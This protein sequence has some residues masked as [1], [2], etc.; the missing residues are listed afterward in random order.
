MEV[1]YM[2]LPLSLAFVA[3]IGGILWWAVFSGQYDDPDHAAH[4]ILRDND[5]PVPQQSQ[6]ISS[7]LDENQSE[8]KA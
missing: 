4:S 2:L 8:P 6:T 5:T 7:N 3:M 1:L